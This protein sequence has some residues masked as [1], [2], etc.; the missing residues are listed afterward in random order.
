MAKARELLALFACREWLA[1]GAELMPQVVAEVE[2]ERVQWEVDVRATLR[3]RMSS[4][5]L[6][7]GIRSIY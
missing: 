7:G 6:V 3:L 5:R 2:A 1:W 4:L